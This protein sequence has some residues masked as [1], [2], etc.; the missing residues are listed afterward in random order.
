M[1]QMCGGTRPA[2]AWPTHSHGSKSVKR[3]LLPCGRAPP[4]SPA[5]SASARPVPGSP[6][7]W[8]SGQFL[9]NPNQR[10][11]CVANSRSVN[12]GEAM[13]GKYSSATASNCHTS[14]RTA[15]Q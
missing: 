4:S 1:A 2:A 11:G 13:N 8:I 7:N 10:R 5:R 15:D 6:G 14:L 12:R 3:L 9:L